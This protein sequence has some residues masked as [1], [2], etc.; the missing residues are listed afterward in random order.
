MNAK[1]KHGV[2]SPFV[3]DFIEDVLQS[4]KK[5]YSFEAI[6]LV[7]KLMLS[8]TKSINI[9]DF[10]AGSK[11]SKSTSRS[12]REIAKNSLKKAAYCEMLFKIANKTNANTILEL[13]TSLGITTS[14]LGKSRR[15]ARI[16]TLEGCPEIAKIATKNFSTLKLNNIKLIV[17]NFDTTLETVLKKEPLFDLIFIDGNHQK[18]PTLRYFNQLLPY[19]NEHTVMIFDDI[20]W[21]KEMEEA[22]TEIIKNEKLTVTID[23]FEMGIVFF[24]KEQL[25]QHFVLRC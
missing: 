11:K 8:E 10:G 20:H 18:E 5:Y 21:S 19:T 24:R 15:N 12:V 25:K 17:G 22:W 2:H 16:Y 7:R 13:G 23:V 3:F 4:N 1:S 6:E 14:Y 9:T